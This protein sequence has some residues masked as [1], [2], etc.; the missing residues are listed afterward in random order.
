MLEMCTSCQSWSSTDVCAALSL[1]NERPVQSVG[2]VKETRILAHDMESDAST[3]N[4]L[5]VLT[6]VNEWTLNY[7]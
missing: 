2:F 4:A 6:W 5:D 1:G 7:P 3:P